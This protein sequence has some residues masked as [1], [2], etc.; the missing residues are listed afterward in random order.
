MPYPTYGVTPVATAPPMATAVRKPVACSSTY[1]VSMSLHHSDTLRDITGAL[2]VWAQPTF[3]AMKHPGLA[4]PCQ[5]LAS[6][7]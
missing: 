4:M 5:R 6:P 3:L 7:L 1:T 2:L